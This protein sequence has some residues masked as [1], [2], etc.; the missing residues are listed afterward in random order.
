MR[1]KIAIRVLQIFENLKDDLDPHIRRTIAYKTHEILS[2][3]EGKEV[4]TKAHLILE[5]F[6]IRDLDPYFWNKK[7]I[8]KKIVIGTT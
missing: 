5:H 7:N 2:R 8:D 3:E 6:K 4:N 1:E